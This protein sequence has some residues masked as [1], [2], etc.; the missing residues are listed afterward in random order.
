MSLG[1]GLVLGIIW[2]FEPSLVNKD[3]QALVIVLLG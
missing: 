1:V 3:V 2:A